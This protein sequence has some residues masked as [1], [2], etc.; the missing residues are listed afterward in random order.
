MPEVILTLAFLQAVVQTS[1]GVSTIRTDGAV[2]QTVQNV[3]GREI[4]VQT[5]EE[6]VIA[7]GPGLE[8]IER[9]IRRFDA[10]GRPGPPEKQ[11]IESRT[12]P[13]DVTEVTT[14]VWR[15][16]INS[17][18][19]LAERSLAVTRKSG[20]NAE[21]TVVVE[22][23]ASDGRFEAFERKEQS[24][25]AT[26]KDRVFENSATQRRDVN[27]RWVD[28]ARAT[29]EESR[30]GATTVENEAQY[31]AATTGGMR[32][33]RQTV[34]RTTATPSGTS[35][36]ET[37]IYLPSLAGRAPAPGESPK[38]AR[39]QIVEY[40][41]TP[42][43]AVETVSVRFVDPSSPGELGRASKVEEITCKGD[44]PPAIMR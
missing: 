27:G 25:L 18:L 35:T 1:G 4:P 41:P 5:V 15:G 19:Q 23:P 42:G 31:E 36:T 24:R 29:R 32:L 17:N 20:E 14:T 40:T 2:V 21:T 30:A 26:G 7:K 16:D 9:T 10:N 38:L 8:V 12:G 13:S 11:R 28:V 6:K 3:N 37:D 34:S 33:V 22:R 39:Q 43:G 44:C